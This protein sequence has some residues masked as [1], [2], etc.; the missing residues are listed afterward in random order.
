MTVVGNGQEAVDAVE[1]ERFDI[2][3]MDLQM[4]VMG[5]LEATKAIRERERDFSRERLRIVAMTAHAMTGDRERC[6]AAG[7]DGYL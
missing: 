5:G 7:M 6:L 1:R 3:L 2:V 4:P